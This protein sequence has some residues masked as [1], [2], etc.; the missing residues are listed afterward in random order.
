[1]TES[2]IVFPR[3]FRRPPQSSQGGYAAGV[4]AGLLDSAA[5]VTLHK[6]PPIERPLRVSH[7]GSGVHLLDGDEL[8]IHAEPCSSIEVEIPDIDLATARA[9]TA[10]PEILAA[11]VA[12]T[13]VL[14]G[15]GRQD[16]FRIFPGRVGEGLVATSW[17][18]PESAVDRSGIPV[19]CTDL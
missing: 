17:R 8:V 10:S 15:S 19:G 5:I 18:I 16:G 7:E 1:M 9:A 4:A 13:C 2:T 12:P 11:H 6:P 3:F 14:C